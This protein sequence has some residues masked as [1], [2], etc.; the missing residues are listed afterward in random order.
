[1][2]PKAKYK[3]LSQSPSSKNGA[4]GVGSKNKESARPRR[5]RLACPNKAELRPKFA[6]RRLERKVSDEKNEPLTPT[7]ALKLRD[8]FSL[9]SEP[10][11][12]P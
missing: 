12:C 2:N 11:V 4:A 10:V 6:P 3:E 1:M 7:G 8:R 5:A 9:L